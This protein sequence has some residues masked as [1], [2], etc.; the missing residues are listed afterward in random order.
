MKFL[1]PS[2]RAFAVMLGVLLVS[3]MPL[4]A[5][6]IT[7][8]VIV[9]ASKAWTGY[10][11][12]FDITGNYLTG[13]S[14]ATADL[15]ASFTPGLAKANALLLQMNTNSYKLDGINNLPDGTPNILLE[16]NFYVDAGTA[17]AGTTV[18]FSG[19]VITNGFP[20][21]PGAYAKATIKEFAAGYAY[22]GQTDVDLTPG[23]FFVTR[24]IQPENIAQY[25]FY[26]KGP[27]AA[28]NSTD[29]ALTVRLAATN[30]APPASAV[31]V[32]VD[33]TQNWQGFLNYSTVGD[34]YVSGFSV[35][36]TDLPGGFLPD[37]T[38]A[39]RLSL[40]INTS[41]YDATDAAAIG[42]Q[43]ANT[44]NKPDGSPNK[45]LETDFYVDVGTLYGGV[46]LTFKGTVESNGLPAGWIAYAVIKE[47]GPGYSYVGA[48]TKRLTA[49]AFSV[50]RA[51]GVGNI[52]QYGFYVY[53]PN[54]AP[55]SPQSLKTVSIFV[56]GTSTPVTLAASRSGSDVQIKFPTQAGVSYSV[57]YKAQLTDSVWLTLGSPVA[58]SGNVATVTDAI[59]GAGVARY[60]RV[61]A[62]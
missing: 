5:Q 38:T 17:F 54:T 59:G 42:G 3:T 52:S 36:T 21:F 40:G 6:T 51:I 61:T 29:A 44:F 11:N 23:A 8:R 14:L 4:R 60:Y 28:P 46:D 32:T 2:L 49:G 7:N 27:N 20:G 56:G 30:T 24:D 58:G 34:A 43:P 39:T 37:Q 26:T 1:P 15:R 57:Q 10:Q 12:I 16:E 13:S 48:V 53:G 47:F 18:E 19:T 45:H 9:D 25:G 35:A 50:N 31:T 55:D 22:V 62:P 41:T 33:P